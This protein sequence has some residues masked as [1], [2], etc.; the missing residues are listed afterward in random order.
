MNNLINNKKEYLLSIP[1]NFSKDDVVDPV[2]GWFNH[3]HKEAL[4]GK[5]KPKFDFENYICFHKNY[6]FKSHTQSYAVYLNEEKFYLVGITKPVTMLMQTDKM[7][8]EVITEILS[9]EIELKDV[10]QE[11]NLFALGNLKSNSDSEKIFLDKISMVK[12]WGVQTLSLPRGVGLSFGHLPYLV[13]T[14]VISRFIKIL[15]ESI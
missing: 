1:D 7:R 4:W 5:S 2:E 12:V 14:T 11:M 13:I 6:Q 3:F 8:I 9:N 15:L 10:K